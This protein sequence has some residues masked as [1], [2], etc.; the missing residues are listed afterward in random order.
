VKKR[1]LA[2]VLISHNMPHVFEVSDRIHINRLGRRL[3]VVDPKQVTM[4]D[5]V[6]MMTGAKEPPA[7][8]EAA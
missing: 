6:A 8:P 7:L 5:A 4:S 3:C 1:G 2:I